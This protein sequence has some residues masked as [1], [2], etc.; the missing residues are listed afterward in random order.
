MRFK[1]FYPR[2]LVGTLLTLIVVL[3]IVTSQMATMG[4]FF[5]AFLIFAIVCA[6]KEYY[7]M[8][9]V[10]GQQPFVKIGLGCTIAYLLALLAMLKFSSLHYLPALVLQLSLITLFVYSFIP[11]PDPLVNLAVTVFGVAYLALPL[12]TILL[13]AYFP[14]PEGLQDSRWWLFYLYAVT[15]MT[16]VG[17]LAFGKLFGKR[18][19]ARH[20]SPNKTVAGAFGGFLVAVAVS[21]CFALAARAFPDWIRMHLTI[22]EALLLGTGIGVISQLGDLAESVLKRD[23]KVKDSNQLPGLGGALDILDSLI[24][25]APLLFF[26]LHSVNS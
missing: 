18:T 4:W 20:I 15:K 5:C 1:N 23:A 12:G 10:K 2:I 13:I 14:F 16:D 11:H 17:A 9:Q 24:F 3:A 6:Q 25:T 7:G 21:I 19:L 8:V 22:P 26:Y